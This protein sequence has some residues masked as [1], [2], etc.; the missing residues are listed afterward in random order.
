MVLK[1]K[2]YKNKIYGKSKSLIFYDILET[3]VFLKKTHNFMR[4]IIYLDHFI[5]NTFLSSF[6]SIVSSKLPDFKVFIF[7]V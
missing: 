7:N 4:S 6:L 3:Q 2:K 5:T 1:I